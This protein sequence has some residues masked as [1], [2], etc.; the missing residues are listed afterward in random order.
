MNYQKE[1]LILGVLSL[2]FGLLLV[3][4]MFLPDIASLKGLVI[5]G[6]PV[7]VLAVVLAGARRVSLWLWKRGD[8]ESGQK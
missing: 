8:I 1:Y 6:A 7:T 5:C 2:V 3:G 4:A